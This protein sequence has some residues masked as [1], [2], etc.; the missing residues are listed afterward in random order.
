MCRVTVKGCSSGGGEGWGTVEL[1]R[2]DALSA[3]ESCDILLCEI[4][5]FCNDV[6]E[7]IYAKNNYGD[8][9]AGRIPDMDSFCTTYN[10]TRLFPRYPSDRKRSFEANLNLHIL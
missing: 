9:E 8:C 5:K 7:W 2:P 4:C 6:T 10:I 3:R 1:A